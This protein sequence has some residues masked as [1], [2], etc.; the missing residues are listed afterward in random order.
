LCIGLEKADKFGGG[1][2][3]G[4]IVDHDISV[5]HKTFHAALKFD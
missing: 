3:L 1:I 4:G 2:C 5:I